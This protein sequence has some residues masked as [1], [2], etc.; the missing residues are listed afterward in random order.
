MLTK[1]MLKLFCR[2]VNRGR[3]KYHNN[4]GRDDFRNSNNLTF[5]KGESSS[6]RGGGS[7]NYKDGNNRGRRG[8]W[9]RMNDYKSN[10]KCYNWQNLGYFARKYNASKNDSQEAEEKFALWVKT[11]CEE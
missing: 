3:E 5:Q 6:N 10:V 11:T 8:R 4:G 1:Q 7:N 2:P 9:G